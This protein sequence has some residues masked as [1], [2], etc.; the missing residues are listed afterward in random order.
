MEF[1][2]TIS[3]EVYREENAKVKE[4]LKDIYFLETQHI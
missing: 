2:E 3:F 1:D 4:T